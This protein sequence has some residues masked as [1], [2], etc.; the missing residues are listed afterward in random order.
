M[1]L[2]HS[3]TPKIKSKWI[4]N[5]NVKPDTIKPDTLSGKQNRTLVDINCSNVFWIPLLGLQNKNK[6]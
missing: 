6:K 1:K 5:L 2:E 3:L 4:K